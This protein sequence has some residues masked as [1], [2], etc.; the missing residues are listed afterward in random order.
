MTHFSYL[1]FLFIFVL[2]LSAEPFSYAADQG[3]QVEY[4]QPYVEPAA[5]RQH[6][7]DELFAR[8]KEARDDQDAAGPIAAIQHIWMDSGSETA[9]VLM[10][11]A[12][13]ALQADHAESAIHILNRIIWLEPDW[14]EAWNKRALIK[15][16]LSDDEGALDD[17]HHVLSLEPRHFAALAGV[18][19]ILHR[20]GHDEKAL[21]AM[22]LSLALYPQQ[23]ELQQ[24]VDEMKESVEGRDI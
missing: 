19:Y 16:S 8:L 6:V 18:G 14:A 5:P 22:R 20:H 17:L 3:R 24:L 9:D 11:R 23:S 12:L 10:A 13:E 2:S 21:E 15:F 4:A 1:R 7:L